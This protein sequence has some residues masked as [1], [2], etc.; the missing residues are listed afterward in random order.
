MERPMLDF[1][2]CS[3][4]CPAVTGKQE[5]SMRF[6][7]MQ[8]PGRHDASDGKATRWSKIDGEWHTFDWRDGKMHKGYLTDIP[9]HPDYTDCCMNFQCC[10]SKMGELAH[11]FG[12]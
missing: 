11:I 12:A 2:P 5:G 8:F 7:P 3:G 10:Q 4:R 1:K 9:E 6:C